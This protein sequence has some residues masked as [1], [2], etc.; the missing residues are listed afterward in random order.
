MVRPSSITEESR[1]ESPCPSSNRGQKVFLKCLTDCCI[2]KCLYSG[3]FCGEALRPLDSA[4]LK[5]RRPFSIFKCK[6]ARSSP[7]PPPKVNPRPAIVPQ[8]PQSRPVHAVLRP[9]CDP[10]HPLRHPL[11][12]KFRGMPPPPRSGTAAEWQM[13]CVCLWVGTGVQ[14]STG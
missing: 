7:P 4:I 2:L 13:M 5:W 12:P 10:P 1:L 8:A 11:L 14:Q 6:A 9:A 3:G